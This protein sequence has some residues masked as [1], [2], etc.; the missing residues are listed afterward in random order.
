VTDVADGESDQ[1]LFATLSA[2]RK[3]T[4]DVESGHRAGLDLL[5]TAER[6]RNEEEEAE[7]EFK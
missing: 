3:R 7:H 5:D 2:Q 4:P 1:G 6:E